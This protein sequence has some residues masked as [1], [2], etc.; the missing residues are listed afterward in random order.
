[1][2]L[3]CVYKLFHTDQ[4][5]KRY[6]PSKKSRMPFQ[7]TVSNYIRLHTVVERVSQKTELKTQREILLPR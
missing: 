7:E 1:M 3:V 4:K 5:K 6:Y 2:L